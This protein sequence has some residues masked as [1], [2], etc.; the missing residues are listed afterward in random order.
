M[1]N[2][3]L[4]KTQLIRCAP[5]H[6][7]PEINQRQGNTILDNLSSAS[8]VLRNLKSRGVTRFVDLKRVN[9]RNI[10]DVEGDEQEDNDNSDEEEMSKRRRLGTGPPAQNS[11]YDMSEPDD[12][13][14]PAP[15]PPA[16]VPTFGELPGV[17]LDLPTVPAAEEA[18]PD[19]RPS[20]GDLPPDYSDIPVPV[21]KLDEQRV[22][23]YQDSQGRLCSYTDNFKE[24][25]KNDKI[26]QDPWIAN[27]LARPYYIP[28]QR[29]HQKGAWHGLFQRQR[30]SSTTTC[31]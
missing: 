2:D 25:M 24:H 11:D 28:D 21:D 20:N 15:Q 26:R 3:S 9:K 8:E 10:D 7:R 6:V 13:H 18:V 27:S 23:V 12:I 17:A 19:T 31:S 14:H 1:N 16:R 5:H 22:T 4:R 30:Q 29:R